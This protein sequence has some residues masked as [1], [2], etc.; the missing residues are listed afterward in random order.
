MVLRRSK[1]AADSIKTIEVIFSVNSTSLIEMSR[2]ETKGRER[3]SFNNLSMC[4]LGVEN[5]I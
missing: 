5:T 4:H 1:V 3:E 2:E